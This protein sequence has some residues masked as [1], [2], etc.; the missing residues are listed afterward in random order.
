MEKGKN[1]QDVPSASVGSGEEA[2]GKEGGTRAPDGAVE[3]TKTENTSHGVGSVVGV[4]KT[5]V[6]HC[7]WDESAEGNDRTGVKN[8]TRATTAETSGFVCR[9]GRRSFRPRRVKNVPRSIP[10]TIAT[11]AYR[12]RFFLLIPAT[13]SQYFGQ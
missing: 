3:R 8:P 1:K 5:L 13:K 10:H 12:A 2:T 11:P 4:R 6:R 9:K 7:G